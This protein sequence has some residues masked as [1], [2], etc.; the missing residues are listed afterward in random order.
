MGTLTI[1]ENQNLKEA[2]EPIVPLPRVEADEPETHDP[3][4]IF[5]IITN[6]IVSLGDTDPVNTEKK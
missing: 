6:P 5:P 3:A 2:L 4:N 1:S